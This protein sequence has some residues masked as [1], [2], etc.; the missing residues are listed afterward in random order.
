MRKREKRQ[1]GLVKGVGVGR[2]EQFSVNGKRSWDSTQD[3][4][5]GCG[6]GSDTR[7]GDVVL[8]WPQLRGQPDLEKRAACALCRNQKKA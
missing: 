5:H 7:A 1:A 4:M 2:A 6:A 3:L 8:S